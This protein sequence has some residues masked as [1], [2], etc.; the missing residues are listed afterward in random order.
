MTEE[1]LNI[2]KDFANND[3]SFYIYDF[4]SFDYETILPLI[5]KAVKEVEKYYKLKEE[6]CK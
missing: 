3:N 4:Q 2:L 1:E 5:D 6:L